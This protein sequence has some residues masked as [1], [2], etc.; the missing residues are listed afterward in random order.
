LEAPR[1]LSSQGTEKTK[2]R[3]GNPAAFLVLLPSP[4]AA[5]NRPPRVNGNKDVKVNAAGS[6]EQEKYEHNT[7]D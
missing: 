6:G 7:G 3:L 2:S 1:R 5:S 4:V